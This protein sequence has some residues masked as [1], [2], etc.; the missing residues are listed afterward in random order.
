MTKPN[1]PQ[2]RLVVINNIPTPYRSYHFAVLHQELQRRE[3]ELQVYYMAKTEPGRFWKYEPA[4]WQYNGRVFAD[5]QPRLR[6][7]KDS[8]GVTFYFNPGIWYDLQRFPPTW[9]LLA[10]SWH[11]PTVAGL[12]LLKPLFRK[13]YLLS[14]AESNVHASRHTTGWVLRVRRMLFQRADGLVIPGKVAEQTITERWGIK[15]AQV[16]HMPN[17]VDDEKFF[18]GAAAGRQQRQQI[19][20][21][22]NIPE[23]NRVILWSARLHEK[24]KGILNFLQA[25]ESAVPDN[26]TIL[27]AGEGPDRGRVEAWLQTRPHLDVR[28]L[29]HLAQHELIPLQGASHVAILPSN[30]DSNPL[31]IIEAMWAGLPILSSLRCGNYP[32]TVIP[33]R[34]GWLIDPTQPESMRQAMAEIVACSDEELACMGQESLVLAR[35]RFASRLVVQRFIDDLE[36]FFPPKA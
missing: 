29:G 20:A 19:F 31:S 11:F 18:A 3:M 30:H 26:L 33:K 35:E 7:S 36:R 6:V 5:F 13:M 32:E 15:P 2:A 12:L 8:P 34:N 23:S 17:L 4:S 1:S 28:L 21:A 14:W 16:I 24:S 27:L 9:V 22:Y 25:V 10:G